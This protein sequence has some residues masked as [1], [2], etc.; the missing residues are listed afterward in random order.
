[1]RCMYCDHTK[2]HKRGKTKRGKEKYQ[3]YVCEKCKKSF[4]ELTGTIYED[5]HLTP[6]DIDLILQYQNQ[7]MNFTQ[8]AKIVGVSPKAVSNLLKTTKQTVIDSTQSIH[9]QIPIVMIKIQ[10]QTIL[11]AILFGISSCR[12]VTITNDG[13]AIV[14]NPIETVSV[15]PNA[16]SRLRSDEP[17]NDPAVDMTANLFRLKNG[18]NKSH[19][20]PPR[21]A[22]D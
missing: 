20:T 6:T 10:F 1:M 13:T 16:G 19:R 15:K 14:A 5:R 8:V 11:L 17:K 4:S 2:T 22:S 18:E 21:A 9:D 7:G 12:T 3:R